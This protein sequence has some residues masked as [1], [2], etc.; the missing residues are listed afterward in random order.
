MNKQMPSLHPSALIPSIQVLVRPAVFDADEV[1]AGLGPAAQVEGFAGREL[2][3]FVV[4]VGE[5]SF[6]LADFGRVVA[7]Y[8]VGRAGADDAREAL[9]VND[10]RGLLVDG[11]GEDA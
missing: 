2:P 9:F 6:R 10:H 5:R 4:R 7:E 11:G 8:E 3:D 1:E